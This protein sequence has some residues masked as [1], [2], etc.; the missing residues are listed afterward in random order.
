MS[1]WFY[2]ISKCE[3]KDILVPLFTFWNPTNDLLQKL[4]HL[5]NQITLLHPLGHFIIF[6]ILTEL[7]CY[8]AH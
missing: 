6:C 5:Q 1:A 7:E 2:A 3:I 4:T 8:A